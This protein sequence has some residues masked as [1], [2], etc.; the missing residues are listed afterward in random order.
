MEYRLSKRVRNIRPSATMSVDSKTKQ[1]VAEGKPVIN[2]SVGEPDFDTPVAAAF[3]GMKAIA[4]GQTRYTP[5]TGSL[6][7]RQAIARKLMTENGLQYPPEGIIVSN[8]AKHSLYNV[9]VSIC[10]DGDEIVLPAPYWVSYPEQIE[11]AGATPVIVH[12][13]ADT[14]YKMTPDALAAA[15]GPKTKA[16][17]LNT[18]SNPT[19]AV[20][21]EEELA[22]LGEVLLRHDVYVILDEIYE[23]LVYSVKQV[24]LAAICPDLRDRILLVN[25]FSKAFAMTGWRLGYVAAPPDVAK[26][27][28]SLQS[29]S[30]GSPSTMSQAAGLTALSNFDPAV[31]HT[32]HHRRDVLV[33]GLNGLPGVTCLMPEGA[34]YAFPD[35]SGVIGQMYEGRTIASSND[36][37]ELLLEVALVASVPG[38]AFGAP[39]HVRFSYA[40][41]DEE[42]TEALERMA[43]FHRKLS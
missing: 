41:A 33:A 31:V 3:A 29:H 9:F 12:C 35:V 23:R 15:I 7:L 32:F 42:V 19:G 11:L 14:G 34:F 25:G 1:L 13:T 28:A 22:A 21:H 8:G 36:Y 18:P 2:M 39:N 40:V 20:Y 37:C 30:T 27:L 6:A 17:L 43:Q 24:S 10:E 38:E 26:A 4:N 16:V 5:A